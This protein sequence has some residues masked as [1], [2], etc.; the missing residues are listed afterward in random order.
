MIRRLA[1]LAVLLVPAAAAH[2]ADPPRFTL[3]A[4]GVFAPPSV[5]YTATR[6]FDAFAE[7]GSITTDYEAGKGP[8]GE[9][10]LTWRFSKSLGVA[11]A[12]SIVSRDTTASYT[13]RVPHPLF[14]NRDRTAEGTVDVNYEESAAHL[15]VVYSGGSG[16][17]DFALFAGP[18]FVSLSA[19]LLGDPVYSQ[20]YPFDSITIT[21]V[22]AR[23]LTDSGIGFNAGASVAYRFSKSFAFGVQG[24]FTRASLS[25]E[26]DG[27]DAV[28]LDAGGL[29]VGAG[30]RFS[31]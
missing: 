23:E 17:L 19:D 15:D 31:F 22:P 21:N 18:S 30:F 5:D 13:T 6:T 27:G 16:S 14:L 1:V 11:L 2:A 25:L 8:G 9:V 3:S 28:D 29:Q 10:G 12:G 7:Q 4:Y 26:P 20:S 24:R